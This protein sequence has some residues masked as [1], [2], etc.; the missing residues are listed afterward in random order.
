[1]A[2]IGNSSHDDGGNGTAND[3]HDEQGGGGLRMFAQTTD[4]ERENG[5]EHDALAKEAEEEEIES[6]ATGNEHDDEHGERCANTEIGQKAFRGKVFHEVATHHSSRHEKPHAE[7]SEPHRGL[8]LGNARTL[9][10]IIDEKTVDAGLGGH[11]AE[12]GRETEEEMGMTEKTGTASTLLQRIVALLAALDFWQRKTQKHEEHQKHHNADDG[13][14]QGDIAVV[15]KHTKSANKR[16]ENPSKPVE[17]LGNV[18]AALCTVGRAEH[19][20]VGI[21]SRF[22]TGEPATDDEQRE[23]EKLKGIDVAARNEHEG[24][25]A[26]KQEASGNARAVAETAD[27]A[28]RRQRH[29]EIST[30]NHCLHEGR[31]GFVHRE[32]ILEMLVEHVKYAVGKAPQKEQGGDENERHQI[33]HTVVGLKEFQLFHTRS[34]FSQGN[35]GSVLQKTRCGGRARRATS[36]A[37]CRCGA[38]Q[39]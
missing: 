19:G 28:A 16:P 5:G 10:G 14:G 20:D 7:Q 32:G 35:D 27:D 38:Y 6:R 23:Q 15:A 25:D 29:D 11:V 26:V 31:A 4:G 2:V 3:A 9:I 34:C 22:Q 1:M 37:R 8:F 33:I 12:Q 39:R 21:G 24:T 18:D 36:G 30:V 13:I 17:R